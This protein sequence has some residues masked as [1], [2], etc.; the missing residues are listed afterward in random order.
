MPTIT[1]KG[2]LPVGEQEKI[3]LSTNNG[4]T[5]YKISDF[6]IMGNKPGATTGGTYEYIAKIFLTD[7]TGNITD[8]VDFSD[9]DLL[10]AIYLQD[11]A[12]A[13]DNPAQVIILDKETFNQDIFVY[14]VDVTGNTEPCNFYIELEKFA[15]DINTS[16]FHTL[17]NIR[18]RKQ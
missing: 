3:H 17:K 8:N 9:S 16:T 11:S 1:Y 14:I 15:I 13:G 4:L 2:Q 10:A 7:Q 12:S 5:G 6:R 18:S